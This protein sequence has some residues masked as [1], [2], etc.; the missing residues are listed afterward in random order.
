[1]KFKRH[2]I[3]TL[4][5]LKWDDVVGAHITDAACPLVP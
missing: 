3:F 4:L 1:M 2:V 5:S